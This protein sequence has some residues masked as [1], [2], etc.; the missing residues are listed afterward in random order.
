MNERINERTTKTKERKKERKMN[1][2]ER[3]ESHLDISK[4]RL[5]SACSRE[6]RLTDANKSHSHSRYDVSE[7]WRNEKRKKDK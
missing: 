1:E 3:N 2:R 5:P 6:Q 7:K 4:F